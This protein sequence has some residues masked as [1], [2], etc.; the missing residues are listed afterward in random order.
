[1]LSIDTIIPLRLKN[2]KVINKL[3]ITDIKKAY[4][5]KPFKKLGYNLFN[6]QQKNYEH[7]PLTIV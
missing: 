6:T 3:Y 7:V 5:S 2:K 4:G 1:M